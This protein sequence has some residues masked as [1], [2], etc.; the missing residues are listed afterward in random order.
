[1]P[2]LHHL[3]CLSSSYSH[4]SSDLEISG[5]NGKNSSP[6]EYFTFVST[7]KIDAYLSYSKLFKVFVL[8]CISC[9]LPL[10]GTVLLS[11]FVA[12]DLF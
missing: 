11:H 4:P 2:V 3:R 10:N 7:N 12:S 5:N 1:M 9:S 8:V 6:L